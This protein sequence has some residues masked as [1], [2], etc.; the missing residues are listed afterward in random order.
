M[1]KLINKNI[2]FIVF[3]E[4]TCNKIFPKMSTD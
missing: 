4:N 3:S 1:H 2:N